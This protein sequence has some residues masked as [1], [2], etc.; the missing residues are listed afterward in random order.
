MSTS[1]EGLNQ[2]STTGEGFDTSD[3]DA[4]NDAERVFPIGLNSGSIIMR[5]APGNAG[6]VYLGFDDTVTTSNGF[7]LEAGDTISID[8]D[9]SQQAIFFVGNNAADEIRWMAIN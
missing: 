5:A 3:L 1:T 6:P 2:P 4:A 7:P 9:V 8:I